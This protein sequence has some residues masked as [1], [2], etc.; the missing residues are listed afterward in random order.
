MI[1]KEFRQI[2]RDKTSLGILLFLPVFLLVMFGY[3]LN[4]DV[5]HIPM[6]VYDADN[7]R[8]S[9]SFIQHFLHSEYFELIDYAND[10]DALERM[11]D[12]EII[13]M[14]VVIPEDFDRKLS[15]GDSVTV[16]FLIDG[17][18]SSSASTTVGYIT[19]AVMDFNRRIVPSILGVESNPLSITGIDV[20]PRIWYNPEL[21]S[22][23]F[24]I[25]GMM[26]FI[27]MMMSVVSTALS[28]VREKERG[29]IEQI[30]VSPVK[31]VELILGKTVPYLIMALAAGSFIL[32]AGYILFNVTV[33]GSILL[34]F[35]VT[36]LFLFC[37]LGL[38]LLIS[39]ISETQQVAF[40]I[41]VVTTM[42]PAFILSGFV[43]PIR[44]MP[45]VIQW[46]TN[47]FPIRFYLEAIRGIMLKGNG[48][49]TIAPQII[50]LFLFGLFFVGVSTIRLKKEFK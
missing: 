27:L 50:I 25:P 10:T 11:L 3:A 38:G 39:T 12:R 46:L 19:I 41:S 33:Q 26:G 37:T 22:A 18:N 13:R 2:F 9:R 29:T 16:Q 40:M 34:L 30:L 24:L 32:L 14:G 7:S 42:L 20:R 8:S 17:A 43:F 44:N 31:P 5:K 23:K 28:V 36:V 48:C 47:I 15:A 49:M 4:F 21:Q 1:V 6:A 35:T 45:V